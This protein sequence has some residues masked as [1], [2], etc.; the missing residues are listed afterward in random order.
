M[1]EKYKRGSKVKNTFIN[2]LKGKLGEEIVKRCLGD[3]ITEVDYQLKL[4]GDGKIDFTLSSDLSKGIQVKTRTSKKG[5]EMT[6]TV[7]LDEIQKNSAIIC[8]LIEEEID[9]A[10]AEYHLVFAGFIPTLF[11]SQNQEN[12]SVRINELLY[13][14]G[15]KWYLKNVEILT[16]QQNIGKSVNIIDS[17]LINT[18][19]SPEAHN[20]NQADSSV[21]EGRNQRDFRTQLDHDTHKSEWQVG[22]TVVHDDYGYGQVT[23]VFGAGNT[24]CLAISFLDQGC[25]IINPNKTPLKRTGKSLDIVALPL[26]VNRNSRSKFNKQKSSNTFIPQEKKQKK[27]CTVSNTEPHDFD[28]QVGDMVFHETYGSGQVT[29]IFGAGRHICLG[30]KFSGQ[31]RKIIDPKTGS[32][33]RVGRE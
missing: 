20:D 5:G 21:D 19:S 22:D 4:G 17:P 12:Q 9:E 24:F 14:S 25:K 32:L 10:Q 15:I 16:E 29:H 30:V 7:S 23:H 27:D 13:S 33:K 26:P 31:G 28:W 11:L 3:F 6:W 2:N 1:A 18:L 8:I